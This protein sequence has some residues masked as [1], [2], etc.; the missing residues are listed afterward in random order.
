MTFLGEEE[1][2]FDFEV[3]QRITELGGFGA[4]AKDAFSKPLGID[5]EA[6]IEYLINEIYKNKAI[7][8]LREQNNKLKDIV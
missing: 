2:V 6:F 4:I 5:I 1:E 8:K 3:D 7:E